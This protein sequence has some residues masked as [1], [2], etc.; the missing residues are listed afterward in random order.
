MLTIKHHLTECISLTL[1]RTPPHPGPASLGG[2]WNGNVPSTR[3]VTVSL[4]VTVRQR[5]GV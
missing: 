1:A 5:F 3:Q 2:V 4:L